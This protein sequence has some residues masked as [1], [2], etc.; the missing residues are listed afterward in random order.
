MIDLDAIERK[1]NTASG[2]LR[3]EADFN[4]SWVDGRR[5]HGNHLS[6]YSIARRIALAEQREEWAGAIDA[7]IARIRELESPRPT[8]KPLA[9]G[10]LESALRMNADEIRAKYSG[11]ENWPIQSFDAQDWAKAFMDKVGCREPIDEEMM[12][13]WFAGALMRGYD[14]YR[15]RGAAAAHLPSERLSRLCEIAHQAFHVLDDA[16]H[17]AIRVASSPTRIDALTAAIDAFVGSED[18]DIHPHLEEI[19]AEAIA[20][21]NH[22]AQASG[23]FRDGIAVGVKVCQDR[24][25]ELAQCRSPYDLTAAAELEAAATAIRAISAPSA[26]GGGR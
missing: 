12:L 6:K 13:T 23:A 26:Q 18:G 24:A 21:W 15:W 22:R 16:E 2:Y 1:A 3:E 4:R 7:L 10:E 9:E 8:P 5:S 20:S 14:E 25:A 19:K 17:T 11:D